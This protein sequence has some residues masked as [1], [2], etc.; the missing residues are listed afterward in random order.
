M[1]ETLSPLVEKVCCFF[2]SPVPEHHLFVDG[3]LPSDS[4]LFIMAHMPKAPKS[5]SQ[6][7]NQVSRQF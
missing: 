7:P 1:G 4:P 3:D 5:D 2:P 6:F